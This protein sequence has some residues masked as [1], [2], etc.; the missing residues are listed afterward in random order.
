MKYKIALYL[1]DIITG[2][3]TFGLAYYW[4]DWKGLILT[5]LICSFIGIERRIFFD[6]EV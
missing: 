2:I 4:F 6:R 1:A 5:F 3:S